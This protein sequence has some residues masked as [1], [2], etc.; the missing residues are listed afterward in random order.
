MCPGHGATFRV[1][2]H[3]CSCFAG[4]SVCS[5]RECLSLE[6][7][8]RPQHFTGAFGWVRGPPGPPGPEALA[9]RSQVLL[10]SDP[11]PRRSAVR[12]SRPLCPGVRL[13]REDLPQR[14]RGPLP[15]LPGPAVWLWALRHGEP[16]LQQAL[17]Q[18]P[19]VL[20]VPLAF[21]GQA[22]S[23][24]LIY[25]AVEECAQICLQGA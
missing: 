13:Q 18:E 16:L 24:A 2:C 5:R 20:P 1:D 11:W 14:L 7:V 23:P 22:G 10:T 25:Q 6:G 17:L 8:P 15:G 9:G 21:R 19:E 4:E 3:V 12:L